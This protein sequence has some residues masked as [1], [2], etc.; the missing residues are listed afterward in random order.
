M[1]QEAH[2][3][4]DIHSFLSAVQ[5]ENKIIRYRK[6][7]VIFLQG[8]ASDAM[9]YIESGALKLT[10]VSAEGKEAVI[11]ITNGGTLIGE[12][13]ISS[14]RPVRFHSAVA[15]TASRL[16]KIERT[17]ILRVLRQGG[18]R[19]IDFI[20]FLLKQNARLQED[21][22]SRLVGSTEQN[23]ARLVSSLAHLRGYQRSLPLP[24]ISQQTIA[25]MMGISRQRVNV[26]MNRAGLAQHPGPATG[27]APFR[28]Q[29][30]TGTNRGSFHSIPET[31]KEN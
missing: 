9:Y 10:L 11:C 31:G 8:D 16:V 24:H 15:L 27:K 22:A 7:D 20:S 3:E 6:R 28:G 2:K 5:C 21:L 25:E 17:A 29:R 26:L 18:D 13:S 12:S 23:L 30:R 4:Y 19:A 14:G 1:R